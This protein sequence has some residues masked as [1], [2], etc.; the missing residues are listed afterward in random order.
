MMAAAA[1]V[2][3]FVAIVLI[4]QRPVRRFARLFAAPTHETPPA[5]LVTG[6]AESGGDRD[7]GGD[8]DTG[9][10]RPA[11]GGRGAGQPNR[12]RATGAAVLA[13]LAMSIGLGGAVGVV[14]GVV[15]G[16]VVF[17]LLR[18][19]ES[20]AVKERKSRMEQDLPVAID[21][22]AAC[23]SAGASPE[24]ALDAIAQALD[25]P[26]GERWAL[27]ADQLRFGADPRTAWSTPPEEPG[28][29]GLASFERAMVRA[30]DSGAPLVA[31]LDRIARDVRAER[32]T[33]ADRRARSVG[34]RAAAPLGLCFLPAFVLVGI[35]PV[36]AAS[37]RSLL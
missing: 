7:R 29:P 24:R 11:A 20:A 10:D 9:H 23:L 6:Q 30:A 4:D 14:G 1:A 37:L 3:V 32:R 16:V 31:V 22:F 18:G 34:V 26:L 12:G 27:V 19:A 28:V 36:V 25:G 33:A 8:R 35:V 15:V 21:V 13:G 17:R 5:R 2:L